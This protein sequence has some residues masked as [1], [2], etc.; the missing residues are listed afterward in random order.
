MVKHRGKDGGVWGKCE[1]MMEIE[2]WAGWIF[3]VH[4]FS[5]ILTQLEALAQEWN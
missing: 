4:T 2:G 3:V 1:E 5:I